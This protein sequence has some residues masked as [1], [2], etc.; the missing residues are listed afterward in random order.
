MINTRYH[1]IHQEAG[2]QVIFENTETG[3]TLYLVVPYET[4]VEQYIQDNIAM[5]E[6]ETA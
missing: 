3:K 2:Y 1:L 5:A 6:V 4:D